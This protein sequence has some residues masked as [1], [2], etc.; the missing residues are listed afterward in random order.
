MDSQIWNRN[1]IFACVAS[2]SFFIGCFFYFSVLPPYVL[3]IGGNEAALGLVIATANLVAMLARPFMGIM[4][5]R[6]GRKRLIFTG[7]CLFI[8]CSMLFNLADNIGIVLLIRI[9]T[10][11]SLA[12]FVTAINAYIADIVPETRR[13][14]AISYFGIFHNVAVAIGPALGWVVITS[15]WTQGLEETMRMVLPVPGPD[16]AGSYHYSSLF[17]FA[18]VL[19]LL[20][21]IACLGMKE[22]KEQLKEVKGFHISL[23]TLFYR[24]GLLPGIINSGLWFLHNGLIAFMPLYSMKLGIENIGLF[25]I[26]YASGMVI[27]RFVG[28]KISDR[29]SRSAAVTPG[30]ILILMSIGLMAWTSSVII[31]FLAGIICG[32]G[33]GMV[34]PALTAIVVDR[35]DETKRGSALATFMMGQDAGLTL[36]AFLLGIIL[37]YTS[38]NGLFLSMGGLIVILL[39]LFV[40]NIENPKKVETL[41]FVEKE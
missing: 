2:F 40:F 35:A 25:F 6:Y 8:V 23:S 17:L 32:F 28:G 21:L 29:F 4:T 38:F 31:L 41:P 14:E 26:Y 27:S 15:S 24:P 13:G 7:A 19:G 20:T 3:G 34:H 30:L 9:L 36:G 22:K 11:V 33:F 18:S 37:T 39:I 10:G 12:F 16:K 5:D 1:F